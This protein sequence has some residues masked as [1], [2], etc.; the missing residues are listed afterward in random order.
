[1]RAVWMLLVACGGGSSSSPAHTKRV[2][3]SEDDVAASTTWGASF[4]SENSGGPGS[5]LGCNV[6]SSYPFPPT[7][8]YQAGELR[9]TG[10]SI[11][12][13]TL[14]PPDYGMN[15]DG[16]VYSGGDPIDIAASGSPDVKRFQGTIEF[17]SRVHVTSP[18][19]MTMLDPKTDL[20]ITWDPIPSMIEVGFYI[21]PNYHISDRYTSCRFDGAVGHGI[22]TA[23]TMAA[24]APFGNVAFSVKSVVRETIDDDVELATI[25]QALAMMLTVPH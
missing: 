13:V 8:T 5:A 16:L 7:I 23:E 10:G 3:I 18:T 25:D 20:A 9:L 14:E 22:V 17:P 2:T 12:T 11:G 4:T 19:A 24:I 15:T 21:P 6:T 1:M